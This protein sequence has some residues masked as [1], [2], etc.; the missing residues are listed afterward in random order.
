M[1]EE[2]CFW[3]NRGRWVL[4]TRANSE[5]YVLFSARDSFGNNRVRAAVEIEGLDDAGDGR[6]SLRGRVLTSGHPVH[7]RYVGGPAPVAM[8]NP[9]S[10]VKSEF[11]DQKT[12]AC[13]CGDLIPLGRDFVRGHD[14]KAIHCRIAKVGSVR[15]F[16]EWFDATWQQ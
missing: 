11:D 13:G 2:E 10:Y 3:L 15:K 16:L 6:R 5:R 8:R 4:G 14:Q 9:I 12:C 1:T 7:D